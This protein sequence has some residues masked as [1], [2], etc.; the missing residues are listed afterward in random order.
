LLQSSLLGSHQH[1]LRYGNIYGFHNAARDEESCE[2]ITEEQRFILSQISQ[3]LEVFKACQEIKCSTHRLIG[4]T[5][6]G[7]DN[8]PINDRNTNTIHE[9]LT[10]LSHY[11]NLLIKELAILH[12]L[13]QLDVLKPWNFQIH[14]SLRECIG[15]LVPYQVMSSISFRVFCR[16]QIYDYLIISALLTLLHDGDIILQFRCIISF[17][18]F[19]FAQMSSRQGR[20]YIEEDF[21][22]LPSIETKKVISWISADITRRKRIGVRKLDPSFTLYGMWRELVPLMQRRLDIFY[23]FTLKSR[24]NPTELNLKG[25]FER[26]GDP[27]LNINYIKCLCDDMIACSPSTCE[28]LGW[29]IQTDLS[30]VGGLFGHM[31]ETLCAGIDVTAV[32]K[33]IKELGKFVNE[34]DNKGIELPKSTRGDP[35]EILAKLAQSHTGV[36][37]ITR[38]FLDFD[39]IPDLVKAITS[40]E[41]ECRHNA[42]VLIQKLFERPITVYWLLQNDIVFRIQELLSKTYETMKHV[43]ITLACQSIGL[44]NTLRRCRNRL[45][46]ASSSPLTD[47]YLLGIKQLLVCLQIYLWELAFNNHRLVYTLHM[48]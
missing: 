13:E 4:L 22:S 32:S 23:T 1:I 40:E 30:K 11:F 2:N 18:N 8:Y 41:N 21:T 27:L 20:L 34:T 39:L 16:F 43:E 10:H 42:T 14:P 29:V 36:E 28:V 33:R 6:C 3:R 46:K 31:Q 37:A 12:I 45:L 44:V 35:L 15:V 5:I 47:E 38:S 7:N 25:K 9:I 17:M 19:I 24:V 26:D 48:V